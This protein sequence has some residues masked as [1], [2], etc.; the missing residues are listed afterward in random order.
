MVISRNI[1]DLPIVH[2]VVCRLF[3]KYSPAKPHS[4]RALS[5]THAPIE[6]RVFRGQMKSLPYGDPCAVLIP[7][8]GSNPCT[9]YHK[10]LRSR[11]ARPT[12][13]NRVHIPA[14]VLL[15]A[16]DAQ[17]IATGLSIVG[18]GGDSG[19]CV[20]MLNVSRAALAVYLPPIHS[21]R[22]TVCRISEAVDAQGC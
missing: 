12:E 9:W 6:T 13:E 2:R 4:A 3:L 8:F 17:T 10:G 16:D 14:V 11:P 22:Q 19:G 15:S 21:L 20:D 7:R 5:I 1:T 18:R